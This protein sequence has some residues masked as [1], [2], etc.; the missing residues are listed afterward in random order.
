MR[1]LIKIEVPVE[2]GNVLAKE[3]TLL[4]MVQSI[5]EDQKPEA[6]YFAVHNGK[7][8]AFLFL[9][10]QD[11]SQLPAIVEP[12]FLAFDG[13]VETMPAMDLKDLIKAGPEIEQAVKT[14][15]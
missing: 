14:Y 12:W 2:R 15:A 6:A 8:T 13:N 3:G 5:L 9:D 7:R 11:P 1:F 10:M 4:K